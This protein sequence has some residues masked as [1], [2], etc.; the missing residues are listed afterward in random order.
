[1]ASA[2]L[3]GGESRSLRAGE[4]RDLPKLVELATADSL[5]GKDKSS[6]NDG[7]F[8]FFKAPKTKVQRYCVILCTYPFCEASIILKKNVYLQKKEWKVG[9]WAD[10]YVHVPIC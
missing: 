7:Y 1:M 3:Q 9:N 8:C 6:R 2:L 4:E 10:V 5:G